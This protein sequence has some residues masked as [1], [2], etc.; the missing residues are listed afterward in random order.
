MGLL[1]FNVE[2]ITGLVMG[3]ISEMMIVPYVGVLGVNIFSSILSL[4]IISIDGKWV[5][6]FISI[7]LLALLGRGWRIDVG[8]SSAAGLSFSVFALLTDGVSL[9][10][11]LISF[12]VAK[13]LLI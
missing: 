11:Y 3:M 4:G 7:S 8:V 5:F 9:F 10:S 2:M 1:P 13:S 12:L 6:V